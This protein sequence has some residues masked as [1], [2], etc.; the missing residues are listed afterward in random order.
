MKKDYHLHPRILD[1]S[2]AFENFIH[3][4]LDNGIK[5]ICITD[6]MPLSVSNA[7]DRIPNGQIKAYCRRV[8]E[9]AKRC[10]DMISIKCGIE[11]D[12]HPSVLDEIQRVL[13]EGDFDYILGSSHMHVFMRDCSPYTFNDFASM[14]I[15][16]SMRAAE[17]GWFHAVSHFDMYR[18]V[19]ENPHRFPLI[20]DGYDVM[21]HEDRIKAFLKTISKR[22]V[23]LEIN[24]HL[25]ETK[26]NLSYTYPQQ[27]IVQWALEEGCAF[28]YGSDAHVPD[29][30]GACLDALKKH[31]VYG[32]ALEKWETEV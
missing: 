22:R 7:G 16:N 3:V 4:A 24:P 6:H 1:P 23:C 25:A 18:F 28:T 31:P 20:D 19:F 26:G 12:Y 30:V 29:S 13:D 9:L 21:K 5:E 14:A 10:E 27:Q 11:I 2:N 8:R 15:E 32:K 17:S